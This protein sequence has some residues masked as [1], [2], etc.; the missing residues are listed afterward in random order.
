M[1]TA[2]ALNFVNHVL[3]GESWARLRL[4]PFAGQSASLS[5]GS[6][7]IRLEIS[8]KG[9]FQ[10]APSGKSDAPPAVT[11]T[12]PADTPLRLLTDRSSLFSAAHIAGSVE[13]AEALGFVFRNL[14]WDAE[15]DLSQLIGDIPAH[16]LGLG[17]QLFAQWHLR[18]AKNLVLN[19]KEY[20]TEETHAISRQVDIAQF[21]RAV[22][23]LRDDC[24]RLE[25]RI[26]QLESR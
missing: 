11:I 23:V 10:T 4:Q 7:V 22:D 12:L 15:E 25:L 14:R 13:F 18:Q 19:I 21:C 17:G 20:L 8:G 24:T 6:F 16:R 5:I 9:L 3:A 2:I 26:Q 1:L